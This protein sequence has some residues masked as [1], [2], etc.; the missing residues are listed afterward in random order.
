MR[1]LAERL[2]VCCPGVKTF[3]GGDKAT[4]F[5]GECPACILSLQIRVRISIYE[6][7]VLGF[8]FRVRD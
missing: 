8:R 2:E 6:R 4:E 1:D 3:D 7:L 5:I